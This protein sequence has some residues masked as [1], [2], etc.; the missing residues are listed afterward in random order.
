MG[1]LF[2]QNKKGQNEKKEDKLDQPQAIS[3]REFF[4]RASVLAGGILL[5]GNLSMLAGCGPSK[6]EKRRYV[7]ELEKAIGQNAKAIGQKRLYE[8]AELAYEYKNLSPQAMAAVVAIRSN[9]EGKPAFENNPPTEEMV[10]NTLMYN[11]EWISGRIGPYQ[12]YFQKQIDEAKK[13]GDIAREKR[14]KRVVSILDG[15]FAVPIEAQNELI[16]KLW[17]KRPLP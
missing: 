3:R 2:R 10:L 6:E 5:A 14:L 13:M 7:E 11:T 9:L 12:V 17:E 1:E 4:K 16:E 15:F 8:L